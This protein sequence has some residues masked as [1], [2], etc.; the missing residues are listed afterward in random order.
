[1][2]WAV[3]LIPV[4]VV[5]VFLAAIYGIASLTRPAAAGVPTASATPG[6]TR[7]A[8]ITSAARACA[9]IAAKPGTSGNIAM[10]AASASAASG[11]GTGSSAGKAELTPLTAAGSSAAGSSA[12]PTSPAG[13]SAA[14]TSPAGSSAAP[15]SPAG[16]SGQAAPLVSVSRVGLPSLTA[17]SGAVEID[18]S[19]SMAQ[20]LEAEESASGGADEIRCSG[21][22]PDIWFVGPGQQAGVAYV[23]LYLMNMDSQPATVDVNVI[24]DSGIVEGS[25]DKGITVPPHGIATE[26]LARY[27]SGSGTVAFN[28]QTSRGRVA[29][30]VWAA[31]GAGARGSWLPPAVAPATHIVIPGLP[32]GGGSV[33][34]FVVVP[35]SADAQVKVVAL[36]AQ[37]SLQP[38]GSQAVEAVPESASSFALTSVGSTGSAVELTA[39]VPVTAAVEVTSG[40]SSD[41]SA[42]TPAVQEQGAVAGNL[43]GAGAASSVE[44]TAPGAAA[45]VRIAV[46][47]AAAN[48]AA[49]SASQ[50]VAIPAAHTV[51]T[52][53]RPPS[54]AKSG[55]PFAFTVT[56]LAGSGP[57]Y[58]ARVLSRNG[59]A[60]SIIGMESALT[61]VRLPPVRGS[62]S[63][64]LP[65]PASVRSPAS[66]RPTSAGP[67]ALSRRRLLVRAVTGVDGLRVEAEQPGEFLHDHVEYQRP[68]LLLVLRAGE[69]R[70][71]VE[72]DARRASRAGGIA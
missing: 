29:A 41:F 45:S 70:A 24:T 39:S 72:H 4:A 31:S 30:A 66:D 8:A 11:T 38:I 57:V 51:T 32:A 40:G 35:G 1:M 26:S 69:Q 18:A 56:P 58:A 46:A 64:I 44:L 71:P 65:L 62:Y 43:S 20:G 17:V 42:A 54:G 21:P 52:A 50:V 49:V 15:T 13:S 55:V 27:A 16:S 10:I 28:V 37:G 2:R 6:T 48:G 53:L 25:A 14:P 47:S 23:Q 19:G 59:A 63:A 67:S 36:T 68:E 12:A 7:S 34:V 22:S 60:E 5:L 3:R 9:P 33:R 61:Q